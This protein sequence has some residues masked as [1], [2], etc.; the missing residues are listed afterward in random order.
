MKNR[1]FGIAFVTGMMITSALMAQEF[2]A[3]KEVKL[4]KKVADFTLPD[5][6]GKVHQ[7]SDY[8]GKIVVIHF[9]SAECPFVMR[10]ENRIK[11]LANLYKDKEVVVLGIDSNVTE[12]REQIRQAIQQRA[13][14]YT[15]LMDQDSKIADRFGAITTPHVYILNRKGRLLYEGAF[16]DQ[17]WA[18][19]NPVKTPYVREVLDA[20]IAKKT[21][22]FSETKTYGCTVKRENEKAS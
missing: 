2:L 5:S 17:G 15:V 11:E 3:K 14:N 8:R 13:I 9:W 7:L 10:Y 19:R 12:S 20:I 4:G 6:S 22:P 18:A 1:V 16:D 21:V